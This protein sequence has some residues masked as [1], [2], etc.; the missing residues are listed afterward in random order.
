MTSAFW[1]IGELGKVFLRLQYVALTLQLH[2]P[3]AGSV[4]MLCALFDPRS[5]PG[6]LVASL[7]RV[8]GAARSLTR[9]SALFL[10]AAA[11]L[12]HDC[13]FCELSLAAYSKDS[14][15]WPRSRGTPPSFVAVV[16][17]VAMFS[18]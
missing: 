11:P 9:A 4:V 3:V 18:L 10:P 7:P 17:S 8:Q 13:S 2:V 15:S 6:A 16:P 1:W 5:R 14:L 12:H